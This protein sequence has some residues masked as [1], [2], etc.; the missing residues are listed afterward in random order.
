MVVGCCKLKKRGDVFG[1]GSSVVLIPTA[2]CCRTNCSAMCPLITRHIHQRSLGA[3]QTQAR[4]QS[5]PFQLIE[6]QLRGRAAHAAS[7][8]SL[9][10]FVCAVLTERAIVS[11]QDTA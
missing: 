8:K 9:L 5:L 6:R 3:F 4:R 11:V 1:G 10:G 7:H 2:A